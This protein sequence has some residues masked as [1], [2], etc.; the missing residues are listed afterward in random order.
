VVASVSL[1]AF[2]ESGAEELPGWVSNGWRSQ[3]FL[4]VILVLL[5]ARFVQRSVK[6]SKAVVEK[7]NDAVGPSREDSWLKSV[8]IL[9]SPYAQKAPTRPYSINTS[10]WA[11]NGP[12]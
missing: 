11:S 4:F 3:Y 6:S 8:Q 12:A 9:S 10:G 7:L 5:I 2:G 1:F